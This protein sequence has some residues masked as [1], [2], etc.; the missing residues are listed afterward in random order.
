[1]MDGHTVIT[2]PI[3]TTS[4]EFLGALKWM[5]HY[6]TNGHGD[7]ITEWD[8][9]NISVRCSMDLLEV[10]DYYQ[11][12]SLIKVCCT[13]LADAIKGKSEEEMRNI[14]SNPP[15]ML[16]ELVIGGEAAEVGQDGK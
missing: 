9:A 4:Q 12:Q 10:A 5:E 2:I 15:S 13:I 16:T 1:M 3:T 7:N 14:L 8:R 11:I 6:S